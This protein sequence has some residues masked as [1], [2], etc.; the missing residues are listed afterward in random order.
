MEELDGDD[1]QLYNTSGQPV[2]RDIVQF[3]EFNQ[4]IARGTLNEEVLKEVPAQVCGF[5]E[6][7]GIVPQA[8]EQ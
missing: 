3:V 8:L 5:M 2:P 6:A 4:C 1:G 7:N